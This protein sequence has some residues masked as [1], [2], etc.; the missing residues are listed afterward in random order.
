LDAYKTELHFHTAEVSPCGRFLPV[1]GIRLLYKKLGYHTVVITDH[2]RN[3][4]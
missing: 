2:F 1:G 4:F 3:V